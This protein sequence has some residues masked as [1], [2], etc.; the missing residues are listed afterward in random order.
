MVY[1]REEQKFESVW[2]LVWLVPVAIIGYGLFVELWG[3][4]HPISIFLLTSALIVSLIV[5]VWFNQIKLIT[6]VRA[7]G[8][9]IHFV[10]MWAQRTI[11]WR[12]IQRVEAITYRPIK[13]FGG[14]GVRWA[15]ARGIVYNARGNRGVRMELSNGERVLIG[16][17]R[18]E[19]LISAITQRIG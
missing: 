14:W 1:F 8:V 7:E 3:G 15:T 19:E 5:A 2:T 13:D 12:D 4:D 10:L 6:E 9:R 11:A 16:S 18:T 17:Q